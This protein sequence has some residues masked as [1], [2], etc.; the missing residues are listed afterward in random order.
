LTYKR[1]KHYG[2]VKLAEKLKNNIVNEARKEQKLQPSLHLPIY[3]NFV[4]KNISTA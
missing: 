4:E 3:E 1:D 2:L